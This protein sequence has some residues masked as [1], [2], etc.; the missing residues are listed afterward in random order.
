M[1]V[2]GIKIIL[3][4][5]LFCK[6]MSFNVETSIKFT[7]QNKILQEKF[8]SSK[9]F[10]RFSSFTTKTIKNFYS[11][12]LENQTDFFKSVWTTQNRAMQRRYNKSI[13]LH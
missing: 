5:D 6:V 11:M 10:G 12:Q 1:E 8:N 2:Y 3:I 13:K 9:V 4:L 7:Q